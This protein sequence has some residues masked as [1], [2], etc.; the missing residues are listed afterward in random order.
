MGAP[1]RVA[2]VGC[3]AFP[4][5]DDD[6]PLLRE[7]LDGAGVPS[8]LVAWDD[9]AVDWG[10]FGLVVLRGTW[11]STARPGEFLAWARGA[12][13]A[14]VLVNPVAVVEWNLDRRTRSRGNAS[15]QR[16]TGGRPA[17]QGSV[18]SPSPPNGK[19]G[20]HATSQ[21]WPSGSAK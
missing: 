14:S 10:S 2:V 4:T 17:R 1:A 18:G 5:L 15:A 8:C 16:S 21:A 12:A 3:R 7:A 19:C 20:F 9:P 11:D 6:W 13:A